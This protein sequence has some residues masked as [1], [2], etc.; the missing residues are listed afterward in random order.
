MRH[1]PAMIRIPQTQSPLSRRFAIAPMMEWTDKE[2]RKP[3][4][5]LKASSISMPYQMLHRA[6]DER[7][8]RRDEVRPRWDLH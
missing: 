4:S 1:L 6:V 2:K 7:R 5:T 8:L 3:G